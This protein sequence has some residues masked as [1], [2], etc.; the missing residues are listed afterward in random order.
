[1]TNIMKG[2]TL[3]D[4]PAIQETV[5]RMDPEQMYIYQKMTGEMI[6]NAKDPN[7]HALHMEAATQ[8]ML[9]LRDGLPVTQLQ[10]NEKELFITVYG[11][12]VL[13]SFEKTE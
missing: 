11:E 5:K 1:M 6:K 13:K 10:N 3:W 4:D 7:P 2:H 9:M 8:I 12:D